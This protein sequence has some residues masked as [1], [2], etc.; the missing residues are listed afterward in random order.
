MNEL[1]IRNKRMFEYKTIRV[2]VGTVLRTS[3]E[4]EKKK[5][6]NS[7]NK[8]KIREFLVKRDHSNVKMKN[9]RNQLRVLHVRILNSYLQG[10]RRIENRRM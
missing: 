1:M 4:P 5:R 8:T 9:I 10:K 2:Q 6:K 3:R 7:I